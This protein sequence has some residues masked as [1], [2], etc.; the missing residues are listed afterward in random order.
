MAGEIINHFNGV[1]IRVIG[2]GELRL[3]L[4]SLSQTKTVTLVPITMTTATNQQPRRLANFSQQRAQLRGYTT[5]FG[6][7]FVIT[8]IVVFV[9]PMFNEFPR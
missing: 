2:T 5:D 9:K 3:K 4:Q 6:D 1:R 7:N 8:R